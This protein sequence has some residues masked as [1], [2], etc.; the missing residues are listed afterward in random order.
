MQNYNY[1]SVL[2]GRETWFEWRIEFKGV[3][4]QSAY[5]NT[6]TKEGW[7]DRIMEENVQ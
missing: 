2:Y 6:W 7:S 1:S 5:E 4:E 3:W